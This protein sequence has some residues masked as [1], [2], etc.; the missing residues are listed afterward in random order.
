MGN[1]PC[2]TLGKDL[3]TTGKDRQ[4]GKCFLAILPGRPK[5]WNGVDEVKR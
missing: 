2:L 1:H 4:N 3:V 5:G